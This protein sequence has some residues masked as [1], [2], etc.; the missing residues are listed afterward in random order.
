MKNDAQLADMAFEPM[1]AAAKG[2]ARAL[3]MLAEK[4]LQRADPVRAYELV[5][6]AKAAA[7]GNAEIA[8]MGSGLIA[9]SIP[10]WHVRM[11]KDQPRNDAF[12]AAIERAV[13]SEK[14]VLDIGSGSGL[15]AMMA[16][17]AGAKHVHSCEMNPA[18]AAVA[19]EIVTANGYGAHIHMHGKSSRLLD[20][21][22]DLGGKPDIIVSEIIGNDLVCEEVL[23][24]MIDTARRL[25]APG[26]QFIPQ[27]GE[28]RVALAWWDRLD[29]R[30]LDDVCGF[31]LTAFNDVLPTRHNVQ[32]GDETLH[33]RG[34]PISL[35]TFDFASTQRWEDRASAEVVS[36]GGAV[37]GVI[38]WFKLT[39]DDTD[40]FENTPG[41]G[42]A[43]SW[44]AVFY[45][46]KA[47][48]ETAA[49][50]RVA[51]AATVAG[52]RLRIWQV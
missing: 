13:T 15:L 46:F 12:L 31:D 41:E 28:I 18:V 37:N 27:S 50:D 35:Y 22:I 17:R 40:S 25:A 38:Q 44:A 36:H 45:P 47:P 48:M 29:E 10:N 24:T 21:E 26:A 16:A 5:H 42:A 32:V 33:F 6:E 14:R 3:M 34:P 2:N 1:V 39:M 49:D 30:Y 52:S 19:K 11:V 8:A 7:P 20:P 43:S 51:I 4:A 23:P 9:G